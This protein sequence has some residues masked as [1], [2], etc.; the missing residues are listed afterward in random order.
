MYREQ[1]SIRTTVDIK[2]YGPVDGEYSF[3][4]DV[5]GGFAAC[6][7]GYPTLD[8]AIAKARKYADEH[9]ARIDGMDYCG[10]TVIL[11]EN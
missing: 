2:V 1:R 10:D 4:V 6:G 5:G 11:E 9:V 8:A 3:H 7:N